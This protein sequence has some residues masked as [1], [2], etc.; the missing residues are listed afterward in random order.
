[1]TDCP[2]PDYDSPDN[3]RW[4]LLRKILETWIR[5]SATPVLVFLVPTWPFTEESSDPT[6]YQA[7]SRELAHDTGCYVHDPLPDLWKYTP[8]ERRAFRF[9]HDVHLTSKG[10]KALAISLAAAIERIMNECRG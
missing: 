5:G 1:M 9:E 7:R 6:N 8:D 3:P 10:H 2:A 4:L